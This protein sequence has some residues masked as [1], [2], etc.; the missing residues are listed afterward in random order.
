[1][2]GDVARISL[3]GLH[4]W[5]WRVRCGIWMLGC[6]LFMSRDCWVFGFLFSFF[7]NNFV[8]CC[9]VCQGNFVL[10]TRLCL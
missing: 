3:S 8:A 2:V 10:S 7:P 1:M 4:S 5:M 6:P 9:F